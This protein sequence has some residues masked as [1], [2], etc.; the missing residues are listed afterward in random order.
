MRA[1]YYNTV[2]VLEKK[3]MDASDLIWEL[4]N[5]NHVL[6]RVFIKKIKFLSLLI[7]FLQ[8]ILTAYQFK[9]SVDG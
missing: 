3:F 1:S 2:C 7:H 8:C 5:T 9:L 6:Y 4:E